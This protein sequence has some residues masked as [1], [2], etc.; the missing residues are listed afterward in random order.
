MALRS[1][2]ASLQAALARA[3]DE[4]RTLA[5]Q[6]EA[7]ERDAALINDMLASTQGEAETLDRAWRA[8]REV[9]AAFV[10]QECAAC[11]WWQ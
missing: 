11:G 8:A 1:Q 3:Q 4:A 10:G 5:T 6:L 2:Q 7:S 9:G